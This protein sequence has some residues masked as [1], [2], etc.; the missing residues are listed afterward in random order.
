MKLRRLT[1]LAVA[2]LALLAAAPAL[3]SLSQGYATTTAIAAGSLVSLDPKSSGSVVVAD[4]NNVARLFG[5]VVPPSS[6]S[7]SLSGTGSG[8]VQVTTT[9]SALV[10]VSTAGGD[11][12]VGDYITISQI[13]GVGQK[14]GTSSAR[15]IGTAQADFNGSGDGV[16][17]RTV[18]DGSGKKEV[19]IGQIPIVIAVSSYTS[20]DGKQSYVIPNWLQN[21]SNTLAGKAVS[22]IRIIIAG[23]ILIVAIISISVLLYSAVRNSIIS[24]G[25]NP[26]SKGGV[27]Q[28]MLAV[29]GFALL[30][31]AVTAVAM[32]LV[33]SR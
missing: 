19:A 3:A 14:V 23:L 29:G 2:A 33:I 21:L 11:I 26:L 25:R 7:I 12:H 30:I 20:T 15:V 28:G 16:T 27:L 10:L 1:G 17:K 9:G 13:A 31:L 22:P 5:V 6:A 4:L 18:D 8:Q 24:I 32:Y